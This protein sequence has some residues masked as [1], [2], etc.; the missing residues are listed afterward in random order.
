MC[1]RIISDL[2]VL[3]FTPNLAAG[4]VL[5]RPASRVIH[6]SELYDATI[7]IASAARRTLSIEFLRFVSSPEGKGQWG[8][9]HAGASLRAVLGNPNIPPAAKSAG[10]RH[11]STALRSNRKI[12]RKKNFFFLLRRW[13]PQPHRHPAF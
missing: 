10:N 13:V 7:F 8:G 6:C 9:A 11:P 2:S 12:L 4:C 3:Q 5:H 1:V